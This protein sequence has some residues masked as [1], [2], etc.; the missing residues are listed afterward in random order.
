M[1]EIND[2]SLRV[3]PY[4]D[5]ERGTIRLGIYKKENGK[6]KLINSVACKILPKDKSFLTSVKN[7]F[8]RLTKSWIKIPN[9]NIL[10]NTNSVAQRLHISK[11]DVNNIANDVNKLKEYA[12]K[13]IEDHTN[14]QIEI[15]SQQ[16]IAKCKKN[17]VKGPEMLIA[18]LT[19]LFYPFQHEIKYDL[20]LLYNPKNHTMS[21]APSFNK[22][23]NYDR[24]LTETILFE[25][26]TVHRDNEKEKFYIDLGD[27]YSITFIERRDWFDDQGNPV[28]R[29][30]PSARH[31]T[32]YG[33]KSNEEKLKIKEE[34]LGIISKGS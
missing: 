5:T 9:T 17:P 3:S 11:E 20:N 21:I 34:V 22:T 28:A 7:F 32:K 12:N 33:M 6:E 2:H 25:K 16:V 8:M 30:T 14:Q 31:E 29:G 18:Q 13:A 27:E 15:N 19:R 26:V 23:Y 1:F 24:E 10:I 4:I